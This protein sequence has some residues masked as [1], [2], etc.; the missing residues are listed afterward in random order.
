M[1]YFVRIS[2]VLVVGFL[3]N[4]CAIR[5]V[6]SPF[7]RVETPVIYDS[8]SVLSWNIQDLG[9]T[10]N[11]EELTRITAILKP[12]DLI[13]IQEVVAGEGGVDAVHRLM[14]ILNNDSQQFQFALS[15]KTNSSSV[16]ASERYV[17]IWRSNTLDLI[18][19]PR[20][21]PYLDEACDREPYQGVFTLTNG[22]DTFAISTFHAVSEKKK[23]ELEVVHLLLIADSTKIQN[24]LICG[25]FNLDEDD[26]AWHPL[27]NKGFK[28]VLDDQPTSLKMRCKDGVYLNHEFDNF[29]WKGSE[30][31]VKNGVVLDEV[32]TCDG[33][34]GFR[35]LSDHLPIV[36]YLKFKVDLK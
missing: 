27:Y 28:N 14:S 15:E 25:D 2:I 5:K 9:Q 23:P 33:L 21:L 35:D 8:I 31:K 11:E 22:R 4:T 26:V 6:S 34:E 13:A 36:T 24:L 32:K 16:Y 20:L 7:I 10:K 17:F 30:M 3:L 12:H 19:T 18:G 1:K 29:F